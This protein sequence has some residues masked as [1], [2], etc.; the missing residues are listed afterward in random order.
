[1]SVEAQLLRKHLAIDPHTRILLSNVSDEALIG[2]IA[3]SGKPVGF[4][5]CDWGL[6][7]S[8]R[9]QLSNCPNITFYRS[10]FP[11]TERSTEQSQIPYNLALIGIPTSPGFAKAL[12]VTALWVMQTGGT[13][14]CAGKKKLGG[15]A[16]LRNMQQIAQ[17]EVLKSGDTSILFSL[18]AG[19]PLD[20]PPEWQTPWKPVPMQYTVR[21]K[22]YTVHSQPGIYSWDALDRGASLLINSLDQLDL[23]KPQRILDAGCGYGL[24]GMVMHD[25]LQPEKTC[26][27][28]KNLLAVHCTQLSVPGETVLAADLLADELSAHEPFDLIF[29]NPPFFDSYTGGTGFM[30]DFA[31]RAARMLSNSGQFLLVGNKH[32]KFA[33][34]LAASFKH[35]EILLDNDAFIIGRGRN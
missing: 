15:N 13:L 6:L 3:A 28:D 12:I 9:A 1:M 32:F 7:R 26:W 17:P 20:I 4:Y 27:V 21:N 30:K 29:C 11:S 2:E 18:K 25:Y 31:P 8:L 33:E 10:V 16:T 24:L 22:S 35:L 14:L 19:S 5:H 23:G 34:A